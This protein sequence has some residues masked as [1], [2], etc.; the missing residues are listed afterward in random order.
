MVLSG[1]QY[2]LKH[3][4]LISD[5]HRLFGVV[6]DEEMDESVANSPEYQ[7]WEHFAGVATN[8]LEKIEQYL[9]SLQAMRNW[10]PCLFLVLYH[11]KVPTFQSKI[12][13]FL[14]NTI[15]FLFTAIQSC[16]CLSGVMIIYL[17]QILGDSFKLTKTCSIVYLLSDKR[18]NNKNVNHKKETLFSVSYEI[19]KLIRSLKK[20]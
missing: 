18:T 1:Y 20:Q 5:E 12:P 2:S 3:S 7:Q 10:P 14:L 19:N 4:Q 6:E 11:S 13:M 17:Y 9:E 15:I 8:L 16:F